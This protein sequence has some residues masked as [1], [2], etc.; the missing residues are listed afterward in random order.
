[1]WTEVEEPVKQAPVRH[2]TYGEMARKTG[3]IHVYSH[4]SALCRSHRPWPRLIRAALRP[5]RNSRWRSMH[6]RALR[7]ASTLN[8]LRKL[9]RLDRVAGNMNIAPCKP[10][11]QAFASPNKIPLFNVQSGRLRPSVFVPNMNL[12]VRRGI[13]SMTRRCI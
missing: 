12:L 13:L 1:M 3:A 7:Q 2:Q 10:R 5:A 9:F 8:I 4:A 11:C 6:H